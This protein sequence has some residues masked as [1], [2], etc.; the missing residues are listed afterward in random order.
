MSLWA[1][2]PREIKNTHLDTEIDR[3]S[4]RQIP[5]HICVCVYL[6]IGID[7]FLDYKSSFFIKTDRGW[8][9]IM[10]ENTVTAFAKVLPF[11]NWASWLWH[12]VSVSRQLCDLRS[13]V[14]HHSV[15]CT[16]AALSPNGQQHPL[17]YKCD[18][19]VSL[20][21]INF[22]APVGETAGHLNHKDHSLT[23]FKSHA[24]TTNT[25]SQWQINL[26]L[27]PDVF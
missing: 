1:V 21:I 8:S 6:H 14:C 25:T 2:S 24:T 22:S 23:T 17:T 9:L 20:D 19:Q 7:I 3:H 18:N 4:I 11:Q 12:T 13:D 15:G 10:R 5:E 26:S 16:V 27:S